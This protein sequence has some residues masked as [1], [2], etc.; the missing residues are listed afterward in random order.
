[1]LF[2]CFF[3]WYKM[4]IGNLY[5]YYGAFF[6]ICSFYSIYSLRNNIYSE[7][8]FILFVLIICIATDLGDIFLENYLKDQS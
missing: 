4:N 6:L 3:E 2:N 7:Y 5:K 8:G 1:M